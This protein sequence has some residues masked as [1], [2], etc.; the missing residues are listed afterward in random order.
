MGD[1][2]AAA[3]RSGV[4]AD[5]SGTE[6]GGGGAVVAAVGIAGMALVG[7]ELAVTAG[8]GSAK[9]GGT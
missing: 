2:G 4:G 3:G 7:A 1:S 9:G 6:T 5:A 8:A